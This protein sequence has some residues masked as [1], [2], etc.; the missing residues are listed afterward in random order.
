MI[1]TDPA[2]DQLI[3]F[4]RWWADHRSEEQA[5][6]WYGGFRDALE[7]LADKPVQCFLARENNLFPDELRE[8]YYGLGS[9][10]THRAIFRIDGD[11]VRVL[12]IRH[13][14][15]EDIAPGDL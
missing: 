1:I 15:Q 4:A 3:E 2:R 6:R 7:S 8:F 14:A 13:L 11:I 9:R 5:L 12:C 10:P